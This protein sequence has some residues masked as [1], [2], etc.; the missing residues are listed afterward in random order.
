MKTQ[1][2]EGQMKSTSLEGLTTTK[3]TIQ[4][5]EGETLSP[6]LSQEL[7]K[8]YKLIVQFPS[9]FIYFSELKL[10]HFCH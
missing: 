5:N 3:Q 9:N 8:V 2:N 1:T 6:D 4:K 10:I 7:K